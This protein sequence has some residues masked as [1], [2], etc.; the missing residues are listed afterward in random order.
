[1]TARWKRLIFIVGVLLAFGAGTAAAKAP[2][3]AAS[4][5]YTAFVEYVK[6][7]DGLAGQP[8]TAPQKDKYE[9]ELSAKKEAAAHK[10][11][12]L[13]NRASDEARATY[14]A[15]AKEQAETVRRIEDD[16]LATI[17]GEFANKLERA[18][19]SYQLKLARVANGRQVFESQ[20]HTQIDKLRADKAATPD[21]ASKNAIQER[22]TALIG[23]IAAKRTELTQKRKELKAAFLDQKQELKAA[24]AGS[25]EK[26][27]QAAEDRIASIATHWK[28]AAD[29]KKATL[30]SKRER[31]LAYLQ[32]KLEQ[33]RADI[34]SMPA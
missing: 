12:A 28:R 32:A 4:A 17:G 11:N 9:T 7:L 6:K 26:V 33:G 18:S 16:E 29:Q 1:M 21:A 22:I 31:Q 30:A 25:E 34:A 5:Q 10:A 27:A 8:T 15:K 24:Q 23:Q 13:F 14:E 2:S 19:A 20:V 3:L